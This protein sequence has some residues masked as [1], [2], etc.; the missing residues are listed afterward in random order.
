MK[1][2]IFKDVID[3]NGANIGQ[4]APDFNLN[5]IVHKQ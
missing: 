1:S 5:I 2:L 4:N 3:I